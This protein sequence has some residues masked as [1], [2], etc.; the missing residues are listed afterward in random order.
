MTKE[1]ASRDA[2][3]GQAVVVGGGIAGLVSALALTGLGFQVCVLEQ[4]RRLR[5]GG[6][7]LTLWPNA[8]RAL[9]ALGLDDV[10]LEI[11]C[12]IHE[13]VTLNPAGSV[14]TTVPIGR[15]ADYFGPLL[16]VRR[17]DLL[18][19]LES[20][21][22]GE[23]L[24]GARVRMADG[25]LCVHG[26]PIDADLI[27]GA[28]G[29]GSE[30]R[31][32]VAPDVVPRSAGYAAWRGIAPTGDRTPRRAS[33]T[34]G[35]GRRFG[36]VPLPGSSTYWF[37]V[38]ADTDRDGGED[39]ERT[40]ADWHEPI[41]EV[42]AA[43]AR[44]DR[45]SLSIADLRALPAWHADRVV[46]VGDAAHAMTPNLGQGAAQA[47]EDVAALARRLEELPLPQALRAYEH[48]RKRRA[49][50][51]VRRSRAI[52]RMAQASNPILA[53]T[54]DLLARHLPTSLVFSQLARVLVP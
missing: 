38:L 23:V 30:V 48:D 8:L 52:G 17:A 25:A 12:P 37:A 39:L 31:A 7:G 11:G 44:D 1:S 22:E 14:L 54:R 10:L 45:S 46:L 50:R 26:A 9:R 19:A 2:V 3:E 51:V 16:S 36:L 40:F 21:F 43:T 41:P 27:V 6:A 4:E 29:I 32:A 34:I 42:L 18:E 28:D 33:E 24:F 20:R 13:A 15:I 49:E 53:G 47:L 35:R 5:S